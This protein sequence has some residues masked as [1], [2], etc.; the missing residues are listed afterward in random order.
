MLFHFRMKRFLCILEDLQ[1]ESRV[2]DNSVSPD[3]SR[4]SGCFCS[5][6][7]FNLNSRVLSED[8]IRVL[9]K[10]LD[11]PP[12]TRKINEN[13]LRQ[14]FQELNENK[15]ALSKQTLR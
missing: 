6:T 4:I 13:E 1:N 8:E 10:R 2:N 5:D 3:E 12:M 15:V 7:F 14:D 9:E 11:F